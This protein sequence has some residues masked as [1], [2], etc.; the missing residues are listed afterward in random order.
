M[1][2]YLQLAPDKLTENES[3]LELDTSTEHLQRAEYASGNTTRFFVAK[4][5]LDDDVASKVSSIKLNSK[6]ELKVEH[7]SNST[8]ENWQVFSYQSG[9]CVHYGEGKTMEIGKF[10]EVLHQQYELTQSHNE[11]QV[12]NE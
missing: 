9:E 2:I 3:V 11:E 5:V 1:N 8:D 6:I 12:N 4:H 7:N 10:F